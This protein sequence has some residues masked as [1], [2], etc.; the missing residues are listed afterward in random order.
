M[1]NMVFF[2]KL[3]QLKP[4]NFKLAH[5]PL[6]SLY[7][8]RLGP[9]GWFGIFRTLEKHKVV[10]F[11][12]HVISSSSQQLTSGFSAANIGM[13]FAQL[14]GEEFKSWDSAYLNNIDT[15]HYVTHSKKDS[16]ARFKITGSHQM[17]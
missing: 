2:N 17:L 12:C 16:R 1:T 5:F 14:C 11:F 3:L 7:L 4:H 10:T 6:V 9:V 13:S 15:L 8:A